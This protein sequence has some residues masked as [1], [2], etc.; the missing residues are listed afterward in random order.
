MEESIA[1]R[2]I[3]I[4]VILGYITAGLSFLGGLFMVGVSFFGRKIVRDAVIATSKGIMLDVTNMTETIS[5]ALL[6]IG[7]FIVVI[8]FIAVLV[9][10]ALARY[11]NWARWVV[12]VSAALGLIAQ[13]FVM[14][15]LFGALCVIV[16]AFLIYFFGFDRAVRDIYLRGSIDTM[17][18]ADLGHDVKHHVRS[19]RDSGAEIKVAGIDTEDT[20]KAKTSKAKTQKSAAKGKTTSEKKTAKGTPKAKKKAKAKGETASTKAKTAKS[21]TK[22]KAKAKGETVSKAK[23]AKKKSAK[24]TG[25]TKKASGTS[26]TSTAKQKT[27]KTKTAKKTAKKKSAKSAKTQRK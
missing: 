4:I 14:R 19:R 13:F 7:L 24:A 3:S 2:V 27:S 17:T 22:K 9:Y 25:Q 26:G 18:F 6:A 1:K 8:S 11:H 16:Y 21:S 23:T 10:H 5:T 12:I 15:G 20:P